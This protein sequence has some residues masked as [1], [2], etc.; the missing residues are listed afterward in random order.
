[1]ALNNIGKLIFRILLIILII[2]LLATS[3][4]GKHEFSDVIKKI[5]S[6]T[7]SGIWDA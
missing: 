1:M 2:I 4:K 7:S 6:L 3:V 5:L